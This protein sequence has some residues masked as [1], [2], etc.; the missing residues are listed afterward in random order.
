MK[1]AIVVLTL[2][3]SLLFAGVPAAISA[4]ELSASNG[5]NE[6][7]IDP[8][9]VTHA[10]LDI[11]QYKIFR[12][13]DGYAALVG[14]S[15]PGDTP[16]PFAFEIAVPA[17]V[18]L[19]WFGEISGGPRETDR[20]FPQPYNVRT[21]DGLD[22]YTAVSFDHVVQ[23]EFL[24]AD[25]TFI[26]RQ[27]ATYSYLL[28]YTPIDDA[29]VLRLSAYLPRGSRVVSPGFEH[30][31]MS[32]MTNEPQ[33]GIT[34]PNVTGGETYSASLD[35]GPPA[36][37]ANLTGGILVTIGIVAVCAIAIIALVLVSK[38]RKSAAVDEQEEYWEEDLEEEDL[39]I[40]QP[41]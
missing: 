24:I 29:S 16:L 25:E 31:S 36:V 11:I 13:P 20:Q 9:T 41:L 39:R 1:R 7:Q 33:Y 32:A 21:A 19:L 18:E 38:R 17:G 30:L 14:A 23:I 28:S 26:N 35:F 27:G 5:D 8:S 4:E 22:I 37:D 3:L 2:I 34:I 6:E 12:A 10:S 15:V 40:R